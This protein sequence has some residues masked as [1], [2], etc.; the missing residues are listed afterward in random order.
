MRL[1]R[2]MPLRHVR[3]REH[4]DRAR[5][6]A[7]A[8]VRRLVLGVPR[9]QARHGAAPD[10]PAARGGRVAPRARR[11]APVRRLHPAAHVRALRRRRVRA[12]PRRR[13]H[14]LPR[15]R[16]QAPRRLLL[17]GHRATRTRSSI[18]LG[19]KRDVTAELADAVR[20]RGHVFGCYYSL[21]DWS[22]PEYPDPERYVDAYMR[23]QIQEL[24]ERFEPALLWGDGHWGHPGRHWRAD[25][26]LADARAVAAERGFD[27]VFNDR[28]FASQHD[29]AVYEYDVPDVAARRPVGAVP[30]A[31]L[32]VLR[33]PQRAGRRPSHR[34]AGGRAARRDRRQGRQPA[35]QRRA[36]RRRHR[37]RDPGADARA[38]RARGSA[39]T[40]TR[41][42]AR[43]VSTT[44]GDG[45]TGTRARRRRCTRSISR[46][47]RSRGSPALDA[48][49]SV[50]ASRRRRARVPCRVGRAR[51]RRPRGRL[52]IRSGR[53]TSSSS[54][55]AD[56]VTVAQPP[57]GRRARGGPP[58]RDDHRSAGGRGRR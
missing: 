54:A 4:R 24:V 58:L 3:A 11:R 49:D 7:G 26:I 29:Y 50:R 48:R 28:W 32:L 19:P 20:R 2:R 22:H 52:A 14:A 10:V 23:P 21:L 53:A 44:P 36:E 8:R 39:R 55:R 16:H 27:L 51:D 41:S 43:P 37:A 31:R 42:T 17:V 13:G 47:R 34:R 5:V 40:P 18:H 57:A 9:D 15:A 12:A 30:G 38:R 33:E 6:R 35:A 56:H 46:R 45:S 25:Q 1:V